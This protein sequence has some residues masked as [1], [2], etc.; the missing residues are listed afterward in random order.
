MCFQI[1]R[2]D[3]KV[4]F[5]VAVLLCCG[6]SAFAQTTAGTITGQVT[7]TSGA[8]VP[9]APVRITNV[10]TNV[11]RDLVTDSAGLYV[12]PSL[13]PGRYRV[14][15]SLTGFRP[16]SK[17]GLVLSLSQTL[18][19][20]FTLEPGAQKQTVTVVATAE[21]LVDT[22]TSTLGQVI[23][24]KPVQDLPLN[25]RNYVN[26]IPMAA[27]VM[28]A[29]GSNNFFINGQRGSGTAYLIDGADVAVAS[30]GPPIV[31]PNLE[32]IGEFK[33]TTNNF[34][35][36][37]GRAL[38]GIVNTHIRSGTSMWHGSMF[39][40]VR[41]TVLDARNFF[42]GKRLPYN[43]NQFGGSLGGPLIKDKLF[44]FGDYQGQ[45]SRA[46]STAFSNVPTAAEAQGNFSDLLPGTKIYKPLTIP[47]VQ[48]PNNIIPPEDVDP[49]AAKMFA[50]LPAPTASGLYNYIKPAVTAGT[51]DSSDLRVDYNLTTKDRLSYVMIFSQL[52]YSFGTLGGGA[53]L[54]PRLSGSLI[55]PVG[56]QNARSYSLNY[57]HI[58][59][60]AM[61]NEFSVG[62]TRYIFYGSGS[63]GMQYE[64]DLG[65]PGLNPSSTDT[66]LSGFPLLYPVGYN[67]FGAPAGGPFNQTQN[68]PQFSDN[69]SWVRGRHSFKTGFSANFRQFNLDQSLFPRGYYIFLAYP[70]AS[71]PSPVLTGG[72]S[73]ATALLG[74]PFEIIRQYL[75]PFGQR[76][77]EYGTYFQD[78]FKATK[79][80]TLNLGVRWDLYKPATEQ[81]NRL[82]NFDPS[83]VT[84]ILAG[85]NGVSNS[86]LD[87]NYRDFS[88]HVGFSYQATADGKTVVRGGYAIAYVSLVAQAVGT[89]TDRLPE[90]PPFNHYAVGIANPIFP[91]VPPILP[92]VSEGF[93][94]PTQDPQHL[95]C[96][97][98]LY[99]IPRSEPT[100]YAQQWNLD[101]QRA[102]PGNFL[103]DVAYVGTR[104]VHLTGS[105]NPN[106]APPGPTPAAGR[107]PIS[108]NISTVL[109]LLSRES[110]FYHALQIKLERRFSAGFFLLGSYTFSKS[111]DDA[112][113]T[114]VN[115]G[116]GSTAQPQD[117]FNWRADRALSNFDARHRMVVSY[118]YELPFGKGKKFLSASN[119]YV[120][121]FLGGWQLNGINSA[122]SGQ[123]FTPALSNGMAAIN[124]GPGGQVRPYLVGNPN[125]S[126][127]Q[128]VDH[129]FNVSAF[130]TPGQAGTA[131]YTFGNAGR[132]IL[133]GPNFVNFDFSLFKN[134]SLTERLKLQFRSEFFN[135]FNHTNFGLPNPSVDLPQAATIRSAAA[136]RQIQFA[137]KLLF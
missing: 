122:Q 23:T 73:A 83:T 29:P 97:V 70:T 123:P 27:G 7:D 75:P 43:F 17:V 12:A 10:D 42:D 113:A 69:L 36:E 128:T 44:I 131:P 59:S 120:N 34:T 5:L 115:G 55:I 80:L 48:F 14:D 20:S 30:D 41:N 108:S 8:M 61:V 77:K 90:N 65:I 3:K 40:Y 116:A 68:I 31:L 135:I 130:V 127:G 88:P 87:T 96:G 63:P 58:V 110:S 37:Y 49:A 100:P 16:E 46:S 4:L 52:E 119:K 98:S 18:T 33:V 91:T 84:V 133:K 92:R 112:S 94:V 101:I 137:L 93:P 60:P 86:T 89:T 24:E 129:W 81:F 22:T 15:V 125:L 132:N 13:L 2:R 111:I 102:L 109:A 19:V 1:S 79:R 71:F 32:S 62:W 121:V 9:N 51:I 74:Y 11:S 126:S 67:W 95:C 76:I 114:S 78:D 50:L 53:P 6:L 72:N 26:L 39:E 25:G 103:L 105:S 64:P 56:G 117:A 85:Q 45:R 99:Y 134:F 124:A 54:G 82:G 21:Q 28:T 104:A 66:H 38:G 47:R 35:A 106:Q 136:P 57:T 118:I 107:E